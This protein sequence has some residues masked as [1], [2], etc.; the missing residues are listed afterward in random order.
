MLCH[1][2][3]G[4]GT[5]IDLTVKPRKNVPCPTCGGKGELR[6]GWRNGLRHEKNPP[7]FDK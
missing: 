4:A 1:A 6:R 2:C 5:V 7:L 3:D